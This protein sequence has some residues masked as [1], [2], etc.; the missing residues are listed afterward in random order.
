MRMVQCRME[1]RRKGGFRYETVGY[2]EERGARMGA[3]VELKGERGLWRV[4]AVGGP[5]VEVSEVVGKQARDRRA[6][7]SIS[8]E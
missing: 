2:I 8:K 5:P 4:I 3:E 7:P 6:L 1:Q